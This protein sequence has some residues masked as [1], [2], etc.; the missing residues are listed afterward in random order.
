MICCPYEDCNISIEIIEINCAIFR[1]GIYKNNG[2]QI[3]P[4]LSKEE[5]DKLKKND[6]IWGCGRPFKLCQESKESNDSSESK[7]IKIIPCDYI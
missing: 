1:C 2:T 7:D 6:E 5:C 4:H 3:N